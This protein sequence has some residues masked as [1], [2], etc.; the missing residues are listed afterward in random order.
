M[1]SMK[2]IGIRF[3]DN[4]FY[5]TFNAFLRCIKDVGI[6]RY[7]HLSKAEI[8]EMFNRSAMGF[9]WTGQNRMS[10]D[11]DRGAARQVSNYF[12]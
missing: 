9:Y 10:Y 6:D 8:A 3:P 4:D 5:Y 11:L 7:S 2:I 1:V 12:G